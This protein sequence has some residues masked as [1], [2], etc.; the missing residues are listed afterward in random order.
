MING[1]KKKR[2]RENPTK[3][4]GPIVQGMVETQMKILEAENDSLCTQGFSM[5]YALTEECTR[6]K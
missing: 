6:L 1:K 2:G 3:R 4:E 5:N